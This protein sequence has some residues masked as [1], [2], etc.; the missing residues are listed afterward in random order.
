M[1]RKRRN[2]PVTLYNNYTNFWKHLSLP[3]EETHAALRW[4]IRRK[5]V[6]ANH[7]PR[8]IFKLFFYHRAPS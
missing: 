3:G 2:D 6:T 4:S 1:N 7:I 8:V 5:M